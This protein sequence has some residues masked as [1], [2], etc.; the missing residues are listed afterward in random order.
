MSESKQTGLIKSIGRLLARTAILSLSFAYLISFFVDGIQSIGI[1]PT[2]WPFT[3]FGQYQASLMPKSNDPLLSAFDNFVII[4]NCAFPGASRL[5]CGIGIIA[6][7]FWSMHDSSAAKPLERG[8]IGLL[9]GAIIGFRLALMFS[10]KAATVLSACLL[11][12]L[13]FCMYLLLADRK[14]QVPELPLIKQH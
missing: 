12:A 2:P 3:G 4:Y 6:A 11:F 10:S 13:F 9:A 5:G 7:A 14:K 8:V 1:A